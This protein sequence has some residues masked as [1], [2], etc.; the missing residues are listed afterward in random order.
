M[1]N[2]GGDAVSYERDTP[3]GVN[4]FRQYPPLRPT[5][6]IL[7][8]EPDTINHQPCTLNPRWYALVNVATP[9][10]VFTP[11]PYA[12]NPEPQILN[13]TPSTMNSQPSIL[14]PYIIRTS[15]Y[16]KYSVSMKIDTRLDHVGHCK[17]AFGTNWSIRWTWP[18]CLKY[19]PRLNP[20]TARQVL[21]NVALGFDT[22]VIIRHGVPDPSLLPEGSEVSLVHV[23][24]SPNQN[25]TLNKT[26]QLVWRLLLR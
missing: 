4:M 7:N 12:L 11:A 24:S 10:S 22:F 16:Y 3:V 14:N 9:L 13:P 18:I 2:W 5:P 25:E 21:V 15:F 8:P 23:F 20:Q 26:S 19:S 1:V 17:T 6:S